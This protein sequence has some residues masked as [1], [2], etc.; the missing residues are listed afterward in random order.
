[1]ID[2]WEGTELEAGDVGKHGGS[3][4][5]DAILDGEA[6]DGTEELVD[7]G[8]GSEIER[9]WAE[10]AGEVGFE[11]GF[12]LLLDVADAEIGVCTRQ[13]GK[14]AAAAGVVDVAADGAGKDGAWLRVAWL[15][16]HFGPRL[17]ELWGYT[18]GVFAKSVEVVWNEGIVK[19]GEN[20]SVEVTDG[21][22]LAG[23]LTAG[24]RSKRLD[25]HRLW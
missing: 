23:R 19:K 7:L 14:A 6:G 16:F 15:R 20:G 3:A 2:G 13:N 21:K 9:V 12:E 25:F 8:G 17:S 5:G 11:I 18:P 22:G 24:S 4:N 1:M 10:V